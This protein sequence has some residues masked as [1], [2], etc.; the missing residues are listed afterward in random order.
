MTMTTRRLFLAGLAGLGLSLQMP[1]R[2]SLA[3]AA[4]DRRLV[5]VILRGALDGMHAVPP[6][7]DPDF[8]RARGAL[9]DADDARRLDAHFG[10]HSSLAEFGKFYDAKQA[11]IVHATASP[12]R[13]R[14][15]FDA[16]DVLETGGTRPFESRA[17]WLNRLSGMVGGEA[18]ALAPTIPLGL[19]GEARATSFAPSDLPE[20]SDDLLAQ[21]ERLYA[22]DQQLRP[23]WASAMDARMVAGEDGGKG[24]SPQ[25]LGQLA[26]RFMKGPD[27]A[28]IVMAEMFGWDT[29]SK[30]AR[31][32][33]VALKSLD[34]FVASLRQ[35]LAG[36]WQDTLVL[37]AT[38]FGRTVAVNGTGGTDH[39]TGTVAFLLGGR[40]AGGR[41][42]ADWPGLAGSSLLEGR[43]LRP[44]IDLRAV[45]AGAAGEHFGLDPATVA[46]TVML[47]AGGLK[48]LADLVKA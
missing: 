26:G 46:A 27:G 22:S 23:L 33:E 10:L 31:R 5:F 34:T 41:V 7:G 29:H 48:P 24:Q 16:Q 32:L 35:E 42:V 21:V 3:R 1:M 4:T 9:A 14:S 37:V 25:R 40:V 18:L 12:Y 45:I 8:A 36:D 19:R 28:R 47:D 2:L 15:H 20:V 11:L 44:T 43:D 39:G 17:G 13:E 30:Q 6:I 38:E